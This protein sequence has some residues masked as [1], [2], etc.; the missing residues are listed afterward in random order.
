MQFGNN[1]GSSTR[2][3]GFYGQQLVTII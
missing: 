3:F 2:T 1:I